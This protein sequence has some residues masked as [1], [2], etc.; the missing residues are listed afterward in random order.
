MSLIDD[1]LTL[2]AAED[3]HNTRWPEDGAARFHVQVSAG[4][5]AATSV[6]FDID[7]NE[8]TWLM[9]VLGKRTRGGK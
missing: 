9:S 8:L 4:H 5:V 6:A 3:R 2:A 7:I 1:L